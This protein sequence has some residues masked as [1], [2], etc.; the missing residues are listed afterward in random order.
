MENASPPNINVGFPTLQNQMMNFLQ[1]AW[2]FWKLKRLGYCGLHGE[3]F[4]P[5]SRTGGCCVCEEELVAQREKEYRA[6]RALQKA[7]AEKILS[8]LQES[9]A[10]YSP[11][12]EQ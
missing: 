4:A 11:K 9:F 12:D 7:E 6:E 2:R 3:P 5:F 8:G 10:I 1:I